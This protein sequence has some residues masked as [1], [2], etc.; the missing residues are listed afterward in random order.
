MR[1]QPD[2]V[3]LI[4]QLGAIAFLLATVALSVGSLRDVS[5]ANE[6][7]LIGREEASLD[8]DELA[9][10]RTVTPEQRPLDETCRRVW[11]DNRRRFFGLDEQVGK[12]STADTP[13]IPSQQLPDNSRA[14]SN[15]PTGSPSQKE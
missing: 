10:C 7:S 1:G 11:A 4:V 5:V 9:R 12:A 8:G 6:R 15:R 3:R 14:G 13:T 2:P